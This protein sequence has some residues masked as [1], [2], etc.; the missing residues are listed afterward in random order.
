MAVTTVMLA[1]VGGQGTILAADV[2]AKVATAA[3]HKVKLSE[4]HGM[5]QRGGSV[6]TVVRFGESVASPITD[7]GHVDHL[8]AF[9]MIEAARRVPYVRP[10]G[11][12]L[13][14]SRVIDPL[15][16]LLGN[17]SVPEDLEARLIAEG[18]IFIDAEQIACEAG[19][20]KSANIVL[21]GA[22]SIGLDFA[23]NDWTD[24]ISDRVPPKMIDVNLEAFRLGR[25][26]CQ[27]G[28]CAQ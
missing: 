12:F 20:P 23:E 3:G 9:E 6:D 25:K 26:A 19:S 13:V 17:A 5:A 22:L 24:V 15:P 14:S 18:V 21:M 8:V 1:G 16:V 28:E 7:F 2:L 4:V 10:G 27:E 11:R